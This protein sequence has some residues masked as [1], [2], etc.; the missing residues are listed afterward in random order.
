MVQNL[1]VVHTNLTDLQ[2]GNVTLPYF[3][4]LTTVRLYSN[5]IR[6]VNQGLITENPSIQSLFLHTNRLTDVPINALELLTNLRY[7]DLSGNK[8]TIIKAFT[9]RW[10]TFLEKLYLQNNDIQK[11]EQHALSGL[12]NLNILGLRNNSMNAFPFDEVR[13]LPKLNNIYFSRNN[14]T[15]LTG[16]KEVSSTPVQLFDLN[17][18]YLRSF[19]DYILRIFPSIQVLFVNYNQISH[20]GPLVIG[21]KSYNLTVLQISHNTLNE[22]PVS[23]LQRLPNLTLLSLKSNR[24][25][26]I[27][28]AAF[29][30]NHRL[31]RIGLSHNQIHFTH[32]ASLKGLHSLEV[33]NL[34]YNDLRRLPSGLFDYVDHDFAFFIDGNNFTCD[35]DTHFL[36]RW[37]KKTRFFFGDVN[38]LIPGSGNYTSLISF[39]FDMICLEAT[40]IGIFTTDVTMTTTV[41]LRKNNLHFSLK[42]AAVSVMIAIALFVIIVIKCVLNRKST[43]GA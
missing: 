39:E 4:N 43:P 8:I 21:Y 17:Q 28:Q 33:L 34:V 23:L 7:L 6:V 37:F 12:L 27:P 14:V 31:R 24:I 26:I 29:K 25:K 20:I 11:I 2:D 1:Y 16:K 35:C 32:E 41:S 15:V 22:I 30:Q 5:G 18:N 19:D 40:S 38:C 42:T 36:K 9:F 13:Y 10:N 3:P